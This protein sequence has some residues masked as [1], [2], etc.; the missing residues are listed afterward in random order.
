[1]LCVTNADSGYYP[2]ITL[3]QKKNRQ[4]MPTRNGAGA[5]GITYLCS[6]NGN[7]TFKL[8]PGEGL[9]VGFTNLFPVMYC[10]KFMALACSLTATCT[11]EA[12][13]RQA[14]VHVMSN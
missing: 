11:E 10:E 12:D 3:L 7:V 2:M 9:L 6:E 13:E 4:H 14:H 5:S 8:L 1:M